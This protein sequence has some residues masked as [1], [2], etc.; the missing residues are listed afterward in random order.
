MGSNP[1]FSKIVGLIIRAFKTTIKGWL[2][3][4]QIDPFIVK[5][6]W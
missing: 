3:L 4:S 5:K 2:L 1:I 6:F